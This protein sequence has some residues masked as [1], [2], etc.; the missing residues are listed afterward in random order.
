MNKPKP[1]TFDREGA[2]DPRT[3]GSKIP[4]RSAS[5][6][7]GPWSRTLTVITSSASSTDTP[8]SESRSEQAN[9]L[10]RMFSIARRSW[11]GS[12]RA[13]AVVGPDRRRRPSPHPSSHAWIAWETI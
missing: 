12:M 2:A 3:K 13:M 6:M 10:R 4:S 5:G 7:P 1:P 8:T 9:A 11:I